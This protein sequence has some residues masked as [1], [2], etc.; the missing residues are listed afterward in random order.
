MVL[1][2]WFIMGVARNP[3][4]LFWSSWCCWRRRKCLWR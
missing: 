3:S 1:V 2:L 4:R